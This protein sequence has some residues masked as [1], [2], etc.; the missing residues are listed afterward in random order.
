MQ[1]V[2][3]AAKAGIG[4]RELEEALLLQAEL[5]ELRASPAGRPAEATVVEARMD[6]GQGPVAT[7]IVTAGTLE[8]GQA[9]VVGCEW[10]KVRS[11]AGPDGRPVD[12][13]L[14]G[15]KAACC[16]LRCNLRS[17][18]KYDQHI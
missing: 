15:R 2:E 5:M 16:N 7:I 3:G 11:L 18:L 1:A 12:R 8:P 13:V 9:V 10:G 17:N 6:K 14:P 4:L